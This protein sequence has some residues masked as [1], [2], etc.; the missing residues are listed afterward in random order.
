[1]KRHLHVACAIIENNGTVLAAQRSASMSLPLK[2]EFPGG[3]IEANESPGECL[4]REVS[5]ELGV[6]VSISMALTPVT[7]NYSDFTVTL[8]PFTCKLTGGNMTPHEHQAIRWV[9]PPNMPE[10][11][12]AAADLPIVSEYLAMLDTAY[13]SA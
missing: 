6:N 7:H 1:M 3:K 8:Y 5:E 13:I 11:D 12:W 10:L 2:W 9:E 4:I